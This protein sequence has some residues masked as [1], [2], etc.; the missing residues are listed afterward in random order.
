MCEEGTEKRHAAVRE[1]HG[2]QMMQRR[3][4][5]MAG[6]MENSLRGGG[7]TALFSCGTGRKTGRRRCRRGKA[8]LRAERRGQGAVGFALCEARLLREKEKT[9]SRN[10]R[11]HGFVF[12]AAAAGGA[13]KIRL[14]AGSRLAE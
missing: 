2:L 3:Q 7:N 1:K 9:E 5:K 12:C 10:A 6:G 8:R 11:E 14:S 4:R 13:A